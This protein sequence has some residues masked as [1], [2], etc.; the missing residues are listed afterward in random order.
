M[1]AHGIIVGRVDGH[2]YLLHHFRG[3]LGLQYVFTYRRIGRLCRI[4]LDVQ[5][6][7]IQRATPCL[8]SCRFPS[9][10]FIL[11]LHLGN[12]SARGESVEP[13][14]G[15]NYE[16]GPHGV[17]VKS[18]DLL[19]VPINRDRRTHQMRSDGSSSRAVRGALCASGF[20]NGWRSDTAL[21]FIL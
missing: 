1:W 8:A 20:I 3:R 16:T 15:L 5:A 18:S 19:Y 9:P 21:L 12:Q 17:T 14:P 11:P 7:G 2:R 6:S 4:E 13:F 10:A